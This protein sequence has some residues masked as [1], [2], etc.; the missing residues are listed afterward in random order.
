M[1]PLGAALEALDAYIA[2]DSSHPDRLLIRHRVRSMLRAYGAIYSDDA[3]KYEVHAVE[4]L[5]LAPLKNLLNGK[6]S[7]Y[8]AAGKIDLIVKEKTGRQQLIIVDHKNV[9]HALDDAR[10]EHLLFDGQGCQYG[11]LELANGVRAD[12]FMHDVLCK[13]AHEPYKTGKTRK[14]AETLEEFEERLL[15]VY[16]DDPKKY[17]ARTRVPL[18]KSNV[19]A[20]VDELY[21]WTKELDMDSKCDTHLKNPEACFDYNRPCKYLGLCSGRSHEEDG[22]WARKEKMHA[23]LELPDGVD[24]KLLITISRMKLFRQ[25][26]LKHDRQYNKGLVKLNEKAEDALYLGSASHKGLEAYWQAIGKLE[27]ER[28]AA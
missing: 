7:G 8:L 22:T 26:R 5:R 4:R 9:S 27:Q 17:F 12:A 13:T 6:D 23:E 1:S 11:Y 14:I 15:G 20:H 25:C 28:K 19:A 3:E 18:L 24:P 10:I 21:H 2:G 16:L